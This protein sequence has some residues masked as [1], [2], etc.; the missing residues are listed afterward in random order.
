M[1]FTAMA[2]PCYCDECNGADKLINADCPGCDE[3]MFGCA[4]L[5]CWNCGASSHFCGGQWD[6]ATGLCACETLWMIRQRHRPHYMAERIQSLWRG[7][8][9]RKE[10]M[11]KRAEE[12]APLETKWRRFDERYR[13]YVVCQNLMVEL[14][15]DDPLWDATATPFYL[16]MLE[17]GGPWIA[18]AE[19]FMYLRGW[20]RPK[21]EVRTTILKRFAVDAMT[22]CGFKESDAWGLLSIVNTFKVPPYE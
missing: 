8:K 7:Y 20:V 2:E 4:A 1:A 11:M 17:V 13:I 21:N 15:K 22:Q 16:W 10:L 12:I 3:K 9:I 6:T 18:D 14:K 5:P 19:H